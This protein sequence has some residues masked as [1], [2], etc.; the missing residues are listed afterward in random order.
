MMTNYSNGLRLALFG[1][2]AITS[3]GLASDGARADPAQVIPSYG[4]M[5]PIA[6]YAVQ[7]DPKLE[8]KVLFSVSGASSAPDKVNGSLERVA[9]FVNILGAGGVRPK[10]GDLVVIVYAGATP[11]IAQD[12]VYEAKTKEAKNPNVALIKELQDAGVT[13]AVCGQ[14]MAGWEIKPDEVLPGVRVDASA[15]TTIATLQ[16]QG[17]AYLPD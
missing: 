2:V 3:C 5:A 15:I 12:K 6:G 17:W 9:R 13:V 14:A 7:P 8:Y 10:P 1:F 16:L 4:K 11:I